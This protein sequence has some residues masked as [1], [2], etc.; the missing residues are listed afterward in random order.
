MPFRKLIKLMANNKN[1]NWYKILIICQ[2]IYLV[3]AFGFI[4][5]QKYLEAMG[6]LYFSGLTIESKKDRNLIIF[7]ANRITITLAVLI[8]VYSL[9]LYLII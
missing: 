9:Y 2:I 3:I 5:Q 8:T 4:Y 1:S 6:L 7:T